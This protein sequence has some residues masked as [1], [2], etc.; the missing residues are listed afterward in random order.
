MEFFT[1]KKISERVTRICDCADTKMYLVEGN[2]MT[3]LIDTGSR[4]GNLY[5][6]VRTLTDKPLIVILTHG[7]LDHAMG[8]GT[9]PYEVPIYMNEMDEALYKK[10]S[11]TKRRQEYVKSQQLLRGQFFYLT[12]IALVFRSLKHPLK[13]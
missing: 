6:Y 9:F 12:M 5:E 2:N 7:H 4:V 13:N 1:S 11:D 3:A 8:T 10:D